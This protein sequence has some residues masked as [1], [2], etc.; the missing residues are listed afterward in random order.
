[1]HDLL[2]DWIGAVKSSQR[3][4]AA[5]VVAGHATDFAA[6]QRL[7]GRYE[8]LSEAL[9]ILEGLQEADDQRRNAL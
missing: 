9:Q 8:G 3:D 4:L 6:Y 1:M 5:A 2:S 7:V